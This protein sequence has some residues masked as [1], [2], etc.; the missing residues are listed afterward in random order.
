RVPDLVES[1]RPP[2]PRERAIPQERL[3][4]EAAGPPEPRR[5][6]HAGTGGG[7]PGTDARGGGPMSPRSV[8][9]RTFR[10]LR[11]RNYRLYFAGQVVSM[12]GTWM[13]WVA[14]GWLVL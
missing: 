4:H 3:P 2:V 11:V 9:T 14:Q 1:R 5:P 13:Q 10:S 12:T 7:D 8:A 6:R